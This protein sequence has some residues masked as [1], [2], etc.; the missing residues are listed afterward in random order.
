MSS[1]IT[2]QIQ[3]HPNTLRFM[4]EIGKGDEYNETSTISR[5]TLL[6]IIC[7]HIKNKNIQCPQNKKIFYMDAPL[8]NLYQ[9]CDE[10]GSFMTT[11]K[12]MGYLFDSTGSME[13]KKSGVKFPGTLAF[14]KIKQKI[15]F[16][17]EIHRHI[18]ENFNDILEYKKH[19]LD[20]K[21]IDYDDLKRFEIKETITHFNDVE[22]EFIS[23]IDM[24]TDVYRDIVSCKRTLVCRMLHDRVVCLKVLGQTT[25][26]NDIIRK[27]VGEYL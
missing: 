27:I 10:V 11:I 6:K 18:R 4:K 14:N 12:C 7:E 2:K 19:L 8:K 22:Y 23:L 15:V 25:H 13:P 20:D 24:M 17:E 16:L 1:G 5:A 26:P 21:S 3:I 9:N